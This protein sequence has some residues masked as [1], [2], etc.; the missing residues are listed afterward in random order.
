M[1]CADRTIRTAAASKNDS[2]ILAIVT[3]E[4]VVAE[5]CYHKSCYRDYTHKGKGAVSSNGDEGECLEYTS[6]ESQAYKM[7]TNIR[8]DLLQKPR[9]VKMSELYT[10]FT[11]FIISQGE[12]EIKESMRT[13]FRRKL[14]GEFC[15]TLDFANFEE[16]SGNNRVFVIPKSFSRLD[17]AKIVTEKSNTRR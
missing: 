8:T 17:L 14:E 5:T 12:T 10:L 9:L 16:L 15:D 4:L 1:I 13:H 3:R 6:A 11:S 7:F 2:R